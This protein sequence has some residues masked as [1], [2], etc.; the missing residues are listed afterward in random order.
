[1]VRHRR[2]SDHGRMETRD[3]APAPATPRRLTRSRDDRMLGGV[4][5][6]I[7]R[8]LDVDPVIVRV[9]TVALVCAVG[10]G[11]VA[12]LA[13]WILMPLDDRPAAPV[14]SAGRGPAPA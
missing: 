1:M 10:V 8:H 14:S 12:Y 5:G 11:A 7:A 4:C 3:H 13:A 2:G 6:G 9:A